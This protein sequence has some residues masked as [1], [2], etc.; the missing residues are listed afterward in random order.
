M[1]LER[2]LNLKSIQ[3][4]YP[5]FQGGMGVGIS[6]HGLASAVGGAGCVGTVSSAALDQLT[7]KRLGKPRMGLIEATAVEIADTIDACGV[8]AINVMVAL[9]SSYE[10]SVRGAIEGGVDMI[11]SGAGLP[12][13]LPSIV[14]RVT[15][16][17]DHGI[18][19]VPIIS[20]SRA[21][22]LIC[23]KWDRQGYRPDA[24]VL[25]GPKA[26]GHLGWNYRQVGAGGPEFLK[27]YDLFDQL[28]DPVLDMSEKYQ[29]GSG[30]IPVIVAG[31]IYTHE[32]VQMALDRGAMG[33]QLGTR[34]AATVESD[35]SAEFKQALLEADS[36]DILLGT[37]DW[38]SPCG[39]PFRYLA[40]SP[41]AVQ[42][43]RM[44]GPFCICTCLLGGAG[45]DNSDK[46]GQKGSP[47]GCPEK[48]VLPPG[49]KPICAATGNN[50]SYKPLFTCGTEAHRVDRILPVQELVNE[51][52][53]GLDEV[54][55]A[56][57]DAVTQERRFVDMA[58]EAL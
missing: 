4:R 30:P 38:G 16:T 57:E 58:V 11:V 54:L 17:N 40:A 8:A 18:S 44:E 14:K 20:S 41:L 47:R 36:E 3:Q 52:V 45:I 48:Y 13:S 1:P 22:E 53:D 33:V 50:T 35:G 32:D 37:E 34:F 27:E 49:E 56:P 24:V 28:L 7:A 6:L 43:N 51:L 23:K 31:G 39:L 42:K 9:F 10:D 15:G 46:L 55:V 12:L 19:L 21:F 2:T 5:I 29:N 25:E 26:G